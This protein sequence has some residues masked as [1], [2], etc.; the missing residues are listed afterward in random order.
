[1]MQQDKELE[2]RTKERVS[3]SE[4]NIVNLDIVLDDAHSISHVGIKERELI[5]Y[6]CKTIV[7]CI[8]GVA[9]RSDYR[10]K[11][12]ATRLMNR[13]I[14]QIDHDQGDV[15][16][17]SGDRDLYRRQRCFPAAPMY[18]IRVTRS[19]AE[20]FGDSN[21]KLV[22]YNQEYLPHVINIHQKEPVRFHR[23]MPEFRAM[24][25]RRTP[26]P[27]WTRTEVF[28]LFDGDDVLGHIVVQEP[29]DDRRGKGSVRAIAEY[30]GVR[31]AIADSIKLLFGQYKMEELLFFVPEHDAEFLHTLHQMG[32]RG[33][34]RNLSGHTFR[35]INLPRLMDRLIPYIEERIGR[36]R[37]ALLNFAQE[38]EKF[39]ITYKQERLELDDESL[40]ALIF[41]TVHEIEGEAISRSGEM[42]E[43]LQALFP[44]PFLWPGLNSY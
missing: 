19:D 35:I 32:I 37:A 12:L 39:T 40:V 22:P 7:G 18:R 4:E 20:Q 10:Q 16:L 13:S 1:M 31:S 38:G 3:I 9:T 34:K 42:A 8:G 41:G 26:A 2:K 23:D 6:G 28:M 17:V 29:R 36:D 43:L 44:L 11:G 15:M 30:A 24:L 33:E 21:I 25:E 14:Q 27:F 5:I